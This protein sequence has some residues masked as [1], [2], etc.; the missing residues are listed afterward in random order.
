MNNKDK[1]GLLS[2]IPA[3]ATPKGSAGQQ[4]RYRKTDS[5]GRKKE[6]ASYSLDS[7]LLDKLERMAYHTR[8]SK[9]EILNA[10][11]A[12]YFEGKDFEPIPGNSAIV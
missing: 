7:P 1:D 2:M 9:S 4:Y 12:K 11:L 8:M 5:K 3:P 6:T 10:I